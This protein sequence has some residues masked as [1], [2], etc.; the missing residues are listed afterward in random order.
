[1]YINI[2]ITFDHSVCL[3]SFFWFYINLLACRAS[4]I[5]DGVWVPAGIQARAVGHLAQPWIPDRE[6]AA[7]LGSAVKK[8]GACT[9]SK[10]PWKTSGN[11]EMV[12]GFHPVIVLLKKCCKIVITPWHGESGRPPNR[13]IV[14]CRFP[15]ECRSSA[16]AGM[17]Y[18]HCLPGWCTNCSGGTWNEDLCETTYNQSL[19]LIAAKY[20]ISWKRGFYFSSGQR[21][22]SVGWHSSFS[23]AISFSFLEYQ[24]R[25]SNGQQD[26]HATNIARISHR[27]CLFLE[28]PPLELQCSAYHGLG[29]NSIRAPELQSVGP[30]PN[31]KLT[32]IS[33]PGNRYPA[34]SSWKASKD[35]PQNVMVSAVDAPTHTVGYLGNNARNGRFYDA[36]LILIS[37]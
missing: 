34:D 14:P 32:S 2:Y 8:V 37:R 12:V 17:E 33:I 26:H 35:P 20:G 29:P 22:Q 3:E 6:M 19:W 10:G 23:K 11:E 16:E 9:P 4:R 36:L 18:S 7:N 25:T 13:V 1:M 28:S 21:E 31:K 30:I 15:F 27:Y 24:N 5:R